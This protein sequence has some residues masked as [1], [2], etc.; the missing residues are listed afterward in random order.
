MQKCL[1]FNAIALFAFILTAALIV[2]LLVATDA[3]T[4]VAEPNDATV[5]AERIIAVSLLLNEP[6]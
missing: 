2:A 6:V 4:S 1:F 3:D 5:I